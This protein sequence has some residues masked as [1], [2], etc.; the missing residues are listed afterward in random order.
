MDVA[1]TLPC[2]QDHFNKLLFLRT[3][4][5]PNENLSLIC[6]VVSEKKVFENV[7]GRTDARVTGILLAHP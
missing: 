7:D 6:P 2:D 3:K 5:S 4:E 1:A